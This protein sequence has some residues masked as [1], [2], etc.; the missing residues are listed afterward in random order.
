M[1][2]G[3][4]LQVAFFICFLGCLNGQNI[5]KYIESTVASDT[6]LDGNV[7]EYKVV[8]RNL[9]GEFTPPT[10][11]GFDVVAGPNFSSNM[12]YINGKM[13]K[14]ATYSYFL[15]A[16]RIGENYIEEAYFTFEGENME[17]EAIPILVLDNPEQI[18]KKYR[19]NANSK[20]QM[21]FPENA[22]PVEKKKKINRPLKKI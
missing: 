14:E 8:I 13:F 19:V 6:I 16:Q 17:T 15:R 7:F 10:L 22:T 11:A 1:G 12:Q 21:L 20:S 5:D 3:L 4:L 2:K 18:E 9:Q